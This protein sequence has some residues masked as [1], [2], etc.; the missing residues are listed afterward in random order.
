V[1]KVAAGLDVTYKFDRVANGAPP[2]KHASTTEA[3]R[4]I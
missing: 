1:Q 3:Y 2:E 4:V